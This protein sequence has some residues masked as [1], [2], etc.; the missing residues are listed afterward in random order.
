[1]DFFIAFMDFFIAFLAG[2]DT[3]MDAL[4]AFIVGGDTFMDAFIAF[5]A[6]GVLCANR[7]H[8]PKM[9]TPSLAKNG[10]GLDYDAVATAKT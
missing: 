4:T 9:A 7:V 10:Y 5:I 8:G 3:F 1:M 2:G 6:G